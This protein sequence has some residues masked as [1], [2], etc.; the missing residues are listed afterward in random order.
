MNSFSEIK[1]YVKK[2]KIL[3]NSYSHYLNNTEIPQFRRHLLERFIFD[4]NLFYNHEYLPFIYQNTKIIN[5][6]QEILNIPVISSNSKYTD[7]SMKIV[8][9]KNILLEKIKDIINTFIIQN[10]KYMS[11]F[12]IIDS[13]SNLNNQRLCINCKEPDSYNS[14]GECLFC[15]HQI[16]EMDL[17][18]VAVLIE[19]ENTNTQSDI[20][21]LT[22]SCSDRKTNWLKKID[23]LQGKCI[24]NFADLNIVSEIVK[25]K[26]GNDPNYICIRKILKASGNEKYYKFAYYFIKLITK[27]TPF[28]F[29]NEELMLILKEYDKI[30]NILDELNIKEPDY[31][32]ILFQ[33]VRRLNL[34]NYDGK[35]YDQI[36]GDIKKIDEQNRLIK[37]F[38]KLNKQKLETEPLWQYYYFYENK[39]KMNII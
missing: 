32:F 9:Q 6:C 39:K 29:K 21:I 30:N 14:E 2:N 18:K 35:D 33:I 23:L 16:D 12:Y 13:S 1:K 19:G 15:Q 22:K 8:I 28:C 10:I 3:I 20:N 11:N 17:V 27:K 37:I 4:F 38:D 25:S 24:P 36:K 26:A 34:Q 5:E 31:L 7:E